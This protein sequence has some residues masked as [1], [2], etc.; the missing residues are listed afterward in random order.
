M[1]SRNTKDV[2][3][4][5]GRRYGFGYAKLN[6]HPFIYLSSAYLPNLPKWHEENTSQV[7]ELSI[8]N[9][10]ES[11]SKLLGMTGSVLGR[12]YPTNL[13]FKTEGQEL[14]GDRIQDAIKKMDESYQP[15]ESKKMISM[16]KKPAIIFSCYQSGIKKPILDNL[17]LHFM[18]PQPPT[19]D[20]QYSVILH[21]NDSAHLQRFL[22]GISEKD[23]LIAKPKIYA[24]YECNYGAGCY[25]ILVPHGSEREAVSLL[26]GKNIYF[27][28]LPIVR[29]LVRSLQPKSKF[30][31]F[32]STIKDEELS[33][34]L[35][36]IQKFFDKPLTL[37]LSDFDETTQKTIKENKKLNQAFL[38]TAEYYRK[39][40]EV[41]DPILP[42]VLRDT[43]LSYR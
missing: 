19:S 14:S 42:P 22:S 26:L 29:Y 21:F 12:N 20:S 5:I 38:L 39:P 27:N 34:S 40:A 28:E 7:P 41:L 30:S 3:Q 23:K 13:E 9:S 4:F 32:F 33:A 25:Q 10:Y 16:E 2:I 24:T 1:K 37:K 35:S 17:V 43:V 8:F 18:F 36:I 6:N 15:L 11:Y 31:L